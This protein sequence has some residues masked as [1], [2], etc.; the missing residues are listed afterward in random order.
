M[1]H[2]ITGVLV[3]KRR[4]RF[5][6]QRSPDEDSSRQD[7][8]GVPSQGRPQVAGS[9]GSERLRAEFSLGASR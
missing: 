3:G 6:T 7:S 9:H 8:Y 1:V 2:P 5:E 4:E